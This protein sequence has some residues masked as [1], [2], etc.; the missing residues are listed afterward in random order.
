[1]KK[2]VN[3]IAASLFSLVLLS[4]MAHADKWKGEIRKSTADNQPKAAFCVPASGSSELNL[5]NVRARINTGGD[6]WWDFETSKYEIPKGSRK[7]S[8]FSGSLWIGGLDVNGQLKLAALRY[9]QV[10]NDYWTGPLTLDGTASIDQPTCALYDKH[11]KITRADVEQFIAFKAGLPMPDGYQVPRVI[12]E[13]PAHPVDGNPNQSYY[14][15]PFF[16]KNGDNMY[17]W[18]DGDYP[19]YDFSNSLCPTNPSNMGRPPRPTMDADTSLPMGGVAKGGMLVDQVLKGD[20]TIWW[21]F[22][23][24]GAAHTESKGEPIGLEIRAQAF[25]FATNDEINNMTFYSYEIINRSTFTLTQTYFSQWVDTDLGDS[26]D[27]YVGCDVRRGLGYCYNGKEVDGTGRYDQ[28]GVQPPAIGVDFFQG[29]YMDPDGYDNPSFRGTG[30]SG[31]TFPNAANPNE[32]SIVTLDGTMLSMTF[33]TLLGVDSTANFLVRAEAING[34]NFGDG[35]VDNERFG[36]RRFVYHN[37]SVGNDA[38]TDPSIAVEY[39]NLLKG[40]WKDNTPMCYGGN[41]YPGNGGDATTP[42]TF[43]FPGNTD[44]WNWGTFG[45]NPG[46]GY[47]STPWTEESAGNAPEDRR[48]MQSAGPFTLLPGAVNYITVGVPWARAASGGPMA[49]VELLKRVD[50][51]CQILFDNCFKVLDG[52]DAPTLVA[53]ELDKEAILYISNVGLTNN[54]GE[55]YTEFD[56]AIPHN[57]VSGNLYDQYYHFEGYQIFQLKESTVSVSDIYD[58]DK[59]RLV[60]QSDIK[61]FDKEKNPIGKLVN[62]TYNDNL[63]GNVPQEMVSGGNEGIKH[64]VKITE[65]QFATGDKRLINFKKY[66]YIAISYA[67]NNYASYSQDP[68]VPNGLNG[69]KR[70]YLAG[71]KGAGGMAITPITVIPHNPAV[72]TNGTAM[73][74]SYG[75]QPQITR[76]EGNGNGGLVLDLTQASIDK[77]MSGAPWKV[78]EA[79]Y[80]P[81]KGPLQIKVIDPLNV[82]AGEFLLKF[83]NPNNLSE[84]DTSFNWEISGGG[85][86]APILSNESIALG[87]EQLIMDLGIAVQIKQFNYEILYPDQTNFPINVVKTQFLESSMV[88]NNPDSPWLTGVPDVDGDTPLN[89]IRSGTLLSGGSQTP[90]LTKSD[91]YFSN[92]VVVGSSQSTF[93][94]WYD[95]DEQYE[96]VVDR[97]WAPYQLCGRWD[98]NPGF[99]EE[100]GFNRNLNKLYSVDIVYTSDKSKWTRCPIVE[101]CDDSTRAESYVEGTSTLRARKLEPRRAHSLDINGNVEAGYGMGWFPGYAINVETGERLNMMFGED[102][103]LVPFNGRDMKFNPTSQVFSS[104]GDV[105]F[106]G[107]H[108]VYVMGHQ[109]NKTTP[110]DGFDCPAYDEGVWLMNRFE[111]IRKANANLRKKKKTDLYTNAMWTSIPLAVPSQQWLSNDCKIRIRVARPYKRYLS[112]TGI[113]PATVTNDN[114]PLY[115]FNTG[116]FATQTNVNEVAKTALDLINVVPN[117]YYGFSSYEINQLDNRIKIINLPVKCV[118]SIYSVNG[119]MVRQFKKDDNTTT[120]VDWDLKNHAGIPI[121]G[122]V[123]IIHVKSDGIGEK[124]IKWFGALRPTDLNSF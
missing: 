114:F 116:I 22:N 41:A 62:F 104:T 43:M 110:D 117:P 100:L 106:G 66:Y 76:I 7:T 94:D 92:T 13:W 39:Y 95:A 36:M 61:N 6:M 97:T 33:K 84:V 121:S 102:S 1:M 118:I 113:A 27:D 29:P 2:L 10:G 93:Q 19:Y 37:N 79:V 69:Q 21:V 86:V 78:E 24:K 96:K 57:D 85:L 18:N 70:T 120:S 73:Q 53:Q 99:P 25:A 75:D 17:N 123:Y 55:K 32:S 122:G 14:L 58:A 50:D 56:P 34:V 71:R 28:Y 60:F 80:Q 107:K 38:Q 42:C 4:P 87:D 59:S 98:N 15:A 31:P 49:S 52:P 48:F 124:V 65:D 108:F 68:N 83:T 11:W 51:K 20:Q 9:R 90:D 44:P 103:W 8:M 112:T 5:N 35:I 115:R 74:A 47:S 119:T 63:N 101:T 40:I 46:A 111:D 64:T 12:K 67:Y 45:K 54:L 77:I 82:K 105:I 72:E 91:F 23:D 16:D 30:V 81:N 109:N 89:W 88:Y 3:L 26:K